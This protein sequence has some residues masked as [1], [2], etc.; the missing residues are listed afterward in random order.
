ML[1]SKGSPFLRLSG[2]GERAV[3]TDYEHFRVFEFAPGK[4][5]GN[6]I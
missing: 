4:V 6:D 1:G 2:L 3:L 5:S